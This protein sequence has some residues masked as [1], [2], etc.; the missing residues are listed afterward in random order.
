MAREEAEVVEHD[1]LADPVRRFRVRT[2]G[3]AF[4]YRE[5][6]RFS[7]ERSPGS[8]VHHLPAT[9]RRG[10][11]EHVEGSE[12]VDARIVIRVLER[13]PDAGL[14]GQVHHHV[15]AMAFEHV[16]QARCSDIGF[17]ESEGIPV[18]GRDREVL[19]PPR[20][21]I[22]HRHDPVTI[23]K[24]AVAQMGADESGAAGYDDRTL[25][26]RGTIAISGR[27]LGVGARV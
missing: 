17:R 6:C 1:L 8:G 4:P 15:G 16:E 12:D 9:D 14:R 11:S 22:V 24:E 25:P 13:R 18:P 10:A 27:R 5:R 3:G 19:S 23:G 2:V 7:V 26:H 21:Q 20:H